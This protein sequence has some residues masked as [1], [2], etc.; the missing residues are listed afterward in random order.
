MAWLNVPHIQQVKSGW[1]L[2][3]CIAIVTAY[4]QQ[5]LLQDDIA[6]WLDTDDLVGTPSRRIT[7]LVRQGFNVTYDDFGTVV[8]L[9]Q[10]LNDQT[11]PILFILTDELSYWTLNTQHAVVLAG[12]SGNEAY[13]FDPALDTGPINVS[14]DELLLAWS[15]FDYTY[16]TLSLA[17][18]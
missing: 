7:R 17:Q 5:L 11:P 14:T 1:C 8:D 9:E 10:W 12:F 6:H 4:L 2:P 13:L 15:H 18:F 3:A 16:A